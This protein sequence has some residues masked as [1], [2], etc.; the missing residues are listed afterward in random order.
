MSHR[1][2]LLTDLSSVWSLMKRCWYRSSA[3]EV[4]DHYQRRGLDGCCTARETTIFS[5]PGTHL[6]PASRRWCCSLYRAA[7]WLR[8]ST[9]GGRR[10]ESSQ[11]SSHQQYKHSQKDLLSQGESTTR[12]WLTGKTLS[13]QILVTG[14]SS[15]KESKADT[16]SVWRSF[17]VGWTLNI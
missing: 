10:G 17:S 9:G 16:E 13:S 1:D 5:F 7:P 11:T 3:Q 14:W 6:P 15:K 8:L 2:P 4:W 12:L